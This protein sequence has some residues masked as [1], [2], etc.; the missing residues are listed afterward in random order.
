MRHAPMTQACTSLSRSAASISGTR[1][2][3]LMMVNTAS[4][5]RPAL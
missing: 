4:L 2:L 3:R 1:E 5:R